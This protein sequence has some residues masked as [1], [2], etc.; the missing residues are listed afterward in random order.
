MQSR[1][2]F[3]PLLFGALVLGCVG[4]LAGD[5]P[6]ATAVPPGPSTSAFECKAGLAPPAV[7]LRRLSRLQYLNTL[8]DLLK[9][10]LPDEAGAVMTGLDPLLASIPVDE[11]EGPNK[12][13]GGFT[14]LA[15]AVSQEQVEGTYAVA[16]G[17]GAA[18]T[19]T[20]ARLAKVAGACATDADAGNDVACLDAFISSFGERALHRA[21]TPDDLAFYKKVAGAAPFDAA[22]WADVISLLLAAPELLYFVESG[23]DAVPGSKD[24]YTMSAY[25]LASRLSYH[26][27]QTMPDD[28]LL[29]H[30]RS[31]DLTQD[32]VFQAQVERMFADPRTRTTIITFYDEWLHRDDVAELTSRLGTPAF[33]TLRG[34]FTPGPSLRESMFTELT[35][36]AT[37]YS[38]DTKGTIEDLY[39]SRKSFAKAADLAEIYGVPVWDGKSE[40]PAFVEPEREGL[41]TRAGMVATGSVNTRPVMKGVFIRRALLCEDIPPPPANANAK[42]IEPTGDLTAREEIAALTETG[43]CAGCHATVINGLGYATENFDA[44]GRFRTEEMLIDGTTGALEGKKPVDTA[45][46]PH[47]VTTDDRVTKDGRE[48]S[49]WMLESGKAQACFARVYF[50]FT[51]GRAEDLIQDACALADLD[52][53]LEKGTDL[54]AVLARVALSPAFRQRN[55]GE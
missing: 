26:F 42:P 6:G 1:I 8:G 38:L 4:N 19:S 53:E 41:L 2:L 11:K 3:P 28:E 29:T 16:N 55:F 48:V 15:Q 7:P 9:Y 40:P 49:R 33:D 30:A 22:D 34:D 5:E 50:R 51:F 54:G 10:A 17:V 46:T 47:V 44:I 13:F 39:T 24:F 52:A 36:M 23:Q 37:H 27:W 25:E 45:S 31:G 12:H 43:I 18:L 21:I 35:D 32:A 14:R 20:P